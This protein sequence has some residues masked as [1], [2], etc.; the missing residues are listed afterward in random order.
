MVKDYITY[1]NG[2]II[3]LTNIVKSKSGTQY[4]WK[5]SVGVKIPFKYNNI[6][7]YFT[8]IGYSN[9]KI[10]IEYHGLIK[11]IMYSHFL[12]EDRCGNVS[13]L[14]NRIAL[15]KPYLIDYVEDKEL[16]YS[17]SS[18]SKEKI[19]IKCPYC[20]YREYITARV[21]YKRVNSCKVCGDGV[22]Y[23]EK[24]I[25]CM[26]KQLNIKY[27]KDIVFEWSD[28]RKYDFYFE[29][30]NKKI[31]IETNGSQ[32]YKVE[33][34]KIGEKARTLKEE[35]ENDK[36]KKELANK[37]IDYY[38]E[39]DCSESNK[40]YII[41][42]I[43]NSDIYS[44]FKKVF[45]NI[46]FDECD[47]FATNNSIFRDVC[48]LWNSND[49]IT[50]TDISNELNLDIGTVIKYLKRGNEHGICNYSNEVGK[51]RGKIKAIKTRYG[52]GV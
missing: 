33:F 47:Y 12:R 37:Y 48:N 38:I 31:I 3:D 32:H 27:K 2:M 19:W 35:E 14:F 13:D 11:T 15:L 49:T 44:I 9:K 24:F 21:L 50:T 8:L 42:S 36:Y 22:S 5:Q 17:L 16:F 45:D 26:L 10:I 28:N 4:E 39:L 40:Q 51:E 46:N 41:N 7:D 34:E 1:K 18:G 30:H 25:S 29:F 23:P 52:T 20:G 6:N 43:Y